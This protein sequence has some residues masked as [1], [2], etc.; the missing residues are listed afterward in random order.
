M[1][2]DEYEYSDSYSYRAL[3]AA[4]TS[5]LDEQIAQQI[6]N[7]IAAPAQAH[8]KI[9]GTIVGLQKAK[10]LIEDTAKRYARDNETQRSLKLVTLGNEQTIEWGV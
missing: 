1:D 9:A 8:D 5:K 3:S 10:S 2:Q 4:F 6:T 7:L